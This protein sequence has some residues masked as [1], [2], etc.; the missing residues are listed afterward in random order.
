VTESHP[1]STDLQNP[2]QAALEGAQLADRYDLGQ[3]R[4]LLTGTQALTRALLSIAQLDA[5]ADRTTG[6]FVS[7]YR[8]S[9]LGGFDRD[10]AAAHAELS[11]ANI[12]FTPGVNEELAATAIWGTQQVGLFPGAKTDGVFALWY[13]K[14]PGV[15]RAG[16]AFK[17][18]NLAGTAPLGGVVAIAGDDHAGISSTTAHQSEFAFI[19]AQI[20]V[21]A[22]SS[23]QD[24][25]DLTV[26]AIALS[27]ASGLWIALKCPSDIIEQAATVD[28]DLDRFI[29]DRPAP[30]GSLHIRWPDRVTD[31]E[32]RLAG[33]KHRAAQ[34]FVH[35][36]GLDRVLWKTGESRIGII[37][38]GKSYADT[39]EA[40]DL[41]GLDENKARAHGIAVYKPAMVWPLEADGLRDFAAGL[42]R[43]I[44]IEEKRP[45]IEPQVR[46]L[47]FDI[48][49]HPNV[50]GKTGT[51]RLDIALAGVLTPGD[52]ARALTPR[53]SAQPGEG[54]E[55]RS[56]PPLARPDRPVLRRP[57]HFCS[58]CPHN[59]STR[60]PDGARALAGIGCHTLALW[61]DPNTQTLTQMGGEGA[62]WIGQAPFTETP[63]VFANIGDGTYYHSGFLAIRAAISAGVNITYKLLFNDAVA[64]TGGQ[65]VEGNLSVPAIA[66]ELVAEGVERIAVVA[67]DPTHYAKDDPFPTDVTVMGRDGFDCA[68]AEL[69]QIIGVSVLI[70]DQACAAEK[71]RRRRRG[72]L[73]DP[74]RYVF[75]N[76]RVCEGCGDCQRA[77]HC[78]SVVPVA[79]PLGEKRR[80][81]L[82]TCNKDETC[83]DGF[84]PA[85]VTIEGGRPR[86]RPFVAP[87][88]VPENLRTLPAPSLPTLEQPW[89]ILTAGI[90]G[91]GVVTIGHVIAMAAHLD[92]RAVAVLDQTGLAQKG[93]AVASHV[94]I[95]TR[96]DAIG[97][98]R[99]GN[100]RA[101]A[102]IG[103]DLVVAADTPQLGAVQPEQTH[104][105]V[106][107]EEAITGAFLR[108]PTLAFPA[109][110][111]L[112]AIAARAGR[113]HVTTADARRLAERLTGQAITAN[114]LL[115]GLAWQIGLVPVS[116]AALIRA[117]ELNGQDT[118]ANMAAFT[119]GRRAGLD[120]ASVRALAGLDTDGKEQTPVSLEAFVT[121][122]AGFLVGYGGDAMAVTY[123]QAVE[124]AQT[125][126]R[127]RGTD[128]DALA[129]AVAEGYAHVL[130]TKDEYEVA[131]LYRDGTFNDAIAQAFEGPVKV[132]YHLAPGWM[133]GWPSK[134][135]GTGYDAAGRPRK[136][137]FGPWLGPVLGLLAW[138]KSLRGSVFDPF[139]FGADRALERRHRAE[140][141]D[142][143]G[144]IAVALTPGSF[145][146]CQ[147]LAHLPTTVRGFGPIR[148]EAF[149][150]AAK[151]RHE[152]LAALKPKGSGQLA[153]E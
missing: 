137:D 121:T 99:I 27:R 22:P 100:A 90:G 118:V 88:E 34:A 9:P 111:L 13:G 73:E 8:G 6:G 80:I 123:R 29:Y 135:N 46:D 104:V 146:L 63:H 95:A 48:P 140:Y 89:R 66:R 28:T 52:V 97:A 130:A 76:E 112:G 51:D 134:H 70:F 81:D 114:V 82:A 67:E 120:M 79:T 64:M 117:I 50:I 113:G 106:N 7:G 15:D 45:L 115:L 60:V 107:T 36:L 37:A 148:Q 129:R 20:P 136:R 30:D 49:A 11:T 16:D 18:A 110:S 69:A 65:K 78:L 4:V 47:L 23:V 32:A 74:A 61:S 56:V 14:G 139:R 41:L 1:P 54:S 55:I 126:A 58:G 133:P 3:A 39:R 98:V 119:W 153:A 103:C 26:A 132:H 94:T 92:G 83:V 38:A 19:D 31:A 68:Q 75:I 101:D 125:I 105:I 147:E 145:D 62:S 141:E 84:C 72:T 86:R 53:L 87:T 21:L 77:S 109:D 2:P 91:T 124:N 143:L 25:L 12:R 144:L 149:D 10:L 44:V 93:G 128:A 152:I 142:D 59:T 151:R 42:D 102:V 24:V 85:I 35:A 138:L 122:R 108:D 5:R 40:L 43:I 71:R 17:H 57:P 127:E 96:D 150:Q 33:P 131:R 116:E